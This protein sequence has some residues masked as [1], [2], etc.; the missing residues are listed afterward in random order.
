MFV[1]LINYHVLYILVCAIVF[2]DWKCNSFVYTSII[3]NAYVMHCVVWLRMAMTSLHDIQL[4]YNLMRPWCNR[5][6]VNKQNV[7][8]QHMNVL[9]NTWILC[10]NYIIIIMLDSQLLVIKVWNLVLIIRSFSF[11]KQIT[12]FVYHEFYTFSISQIHLFSMPTT[13]LEGFYYHSLLFGLQILSFFLAKSFY[14][15]CQTNLY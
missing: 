15:Y 8:I 13:L 9:Y 6:S 12:V 7:V 1:I 10:L 11:Q 3:L 4:L 5:W 2:Y 14:T